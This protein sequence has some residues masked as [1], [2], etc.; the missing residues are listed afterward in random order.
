MTNYLFT[1]AAGSEP[2]DRN[3]LG[4]EGQLHCLAPV[5][6]HGLQHFQGT[7]MV[8]VPPC[9]FCFYS[10]CLNLFLEK[11]FEALK[12]FWTVLCTTRASAVA[13]FLTCSLFLRHAI[14]AVASIREADQLI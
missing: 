7:N 11:G 9:V 2:A 12:F 1:R 6:R 5:P 4:G 13:L 14:V 8:P 3:G 10:Q